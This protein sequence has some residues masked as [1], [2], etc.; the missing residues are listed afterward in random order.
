[1]FNR[2]KQI[3][4]Y[5]RNISKS[6]DI[7]KKDTIIQSIP[8]LTY[9]NRAKKFIDYNK[10]DEAEKILKD[11][12][13]LPQKDALVYKYLGVIYERTGKFEA[14]VENYQI[15]ADLN[16][17]DKIIWQRLGFA[18]I[19]FGEFERAVKSFENAEKVQPANTDTYCGW[20]MSLMKLK[21]YSEAHEKFTFAIKLNKYNYS[22]LFLS[23]VM[24]IKLQMYDIAEQK[25]K[26]LVNNTP[27]EGNTFELAKLKNIKGHK[28]DA[29]ELAK[30]SITINRNMLPAYIMLGQLYSEITEYEN[31]MKMFEEAENR[32]LKTPQL[33]LEWGKALQ[34]MQKYDEAKQKLLKSY[35]LDN[36]NMDTMTQLG[37]CCAFRKEFE[38]AESLLNK[39]TDTENKIVKQARGII[40]YEKG[41]IDKAIQIF[42]TNDEDAVNCFYLAKCYE[43]EDEA[44]TRDYYESAIR[45]DSQY[46]TA[47]V[48]YINFLI[49]KKD[50]LDAQRK[51]RK[52]LKYYENDIDLL[53]LMFYVSYILVKDNLYEYNL[54]E[55][56]SIAQKI[57]CLGEFKYPE[58]KQ[59]LIILKDKN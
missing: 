59:E 57:E 12:L 8:S 11:A 1:M 3:I 36:Q 29:I 28:Q 19:S 17:S 6:I 24:E 40:S 43:I 58:Q 53:N 32:D 54:K 25:L 35:E 41:E 33:Y 14:A 18:L 38:E 39:V 56:L 52:A 13:M 48:N 9:V 47:Y 21:K 27:N 45:L 37:L 31:S 44:K 49:S 20:G 15:S 50:F 7:Y 42:R 34:K 30:K 55:T 4:E 10:F 16:P 22:A 23:A 26:F 51:L 5:I 2:L 46:Y